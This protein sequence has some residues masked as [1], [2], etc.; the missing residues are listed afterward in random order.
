MKTASQLNR[1]KACPASETL[2]HTDVSTVWAERS[3]AIHTYLQHLDELGQIGALEK[4]P[5]QYRDECRAL[6]VDIPLG[7]RTEVAYAYD[8]DTKEAWE[9]EGCK[10][11]EYHKYVDAA[12][13]NIICGTLDLEH[14]TEDRARV[15][16]WKS[17]GK[18]YPKPHTQP[19]MMFYGMCVSKVRE[20]GVVDLQYRQLDTGISPR[21]TV[22]TFDFVAFEGELLRI[23]KAVGV[24]KRTPAA[25]QVYNQGE[26]CRYCPA[27]DSCP[28][29]LRMMD[30]AHTGELE[31]EVHLN[32]GAGAVRD[33]AH[34][35]QMYAQYEAAKLM[36]SRMSDI[37]HA[38]AKEE[39]FECKPGVMFG[40]VEKLGNEKL[41]GPIAHQV[42]EEIHGTDAADA[43]CRRKCTKKDLERAIK[44]AVPRGQGKKAIDATLEAIRA[45]GGSERKLTKKI[46]KYPKQLKGDS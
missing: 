46:T 10:D 22:D 35:Q 30:R 32:W 45:R 29:R 15:D 12:N 24:A 1:I 36:V 27:Q 19:A 8:L 40:E 17:G 11:R 13:P 16:D 33:P 20:R 14:I 43:A 21:S 3:N 41:H 5:Q 28:P 37:L 4:I 38:I 2:P 44:A 31:R 18:R 7:A 42:V 9:L 39:A 25:S 23:R 34:L 6:D 26:H